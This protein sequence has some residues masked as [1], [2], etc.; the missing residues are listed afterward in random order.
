MSELSDKLAYTEQPQYGYIT[1]E[2]GLVDE[3]WMLATPVA[4]GAKN[5]VNNAIQNA[6]RAKLVQQLLDKKQVW[7]IP[8]RK[9]SGNPELAIQTLK[10]S[11]Q[12]FVPNADGQNTDFVW[13]EYIP[14]IKEGEK[15]GGY[16]LAHIEGRRNEEGIN[17]SDFLDSLANLFR[18]GQRYKKENHPGRYYIG[19]DNQEAIIRTDYNDKPWYWLNSAYFKNKDK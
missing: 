9:A 16:G 15:G 12:G 14:P 3:T 17:G 8:Y 4:M 7:G 6:A 1:N 18:L 13:G 10:E 5:L 2:P 11:R 19:T